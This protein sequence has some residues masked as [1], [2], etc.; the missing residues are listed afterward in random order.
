MSPA[1][2]TRLAERIEYWV[3]NDSPKNALLWIVKSLRAYAAGQDQPAES[4][5]ERGEPQVETSGISA[6]QS[7]A[8][9]VAWIATHGEAVLHFAAADGWRV[10][11]VLHESPPAQAGDRPTPAAHCSV[12]FAHP[13]HDFCNGSAAPVNES[14]AD[15]LYVEAPDR[16]DG[17]PELP[18]SAASQVP[19]QATAR[20]ADSTPLPDS[21]PASAAPL[22]EAVQFALDD[23]K[24]QRVSHLDLER[25]A[26]LAMREAES[27]LAIAA[28]Q[29]DSLAASLRQ[30]EAEREALRIEAKKWKDLHDIHQMAYRIDASRGKP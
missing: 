9:P 13:A 5:L 22:P 17:W 8:R 14:A 1:E 18:E 30:V 16:F 25:I 21:S 20:E 27:K 23:L 28:R 3:S 24:L 12:S 2:A 6:A 7:S 29:V 26:R 4:A 10:E 19:V 15:P 11:A